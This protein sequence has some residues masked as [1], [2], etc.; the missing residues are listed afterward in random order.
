[1]A[2]IIWYRRIWS[3]YSRRLKNTLILFSGLNWAKNVQFGAVADIYGQKET[4]RS[5]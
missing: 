1:M 4:Y 2:H 3:S 5:V